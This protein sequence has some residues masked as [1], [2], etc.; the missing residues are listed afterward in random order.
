M[1]HYSHHSPNV[2]GCCIIGMF[3]A[4]FY[5]IWRI[6]RA[7]AVFSWQITVYF[8][9]FIYYFYMWPLLA[10]EYLWKRGG[11]YRMLGISLLVILAIVFLIAVLS[12]P[13]SAPVSPQPT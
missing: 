4:V 9:K 11:I 8:I 13:S 12:G 5:A 7:V 10:F 3:L 1:S 2:S 6:I